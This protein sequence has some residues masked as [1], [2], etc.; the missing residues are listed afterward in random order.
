MQ[1]DT[2]IIIADIK[3]ASQSGSV[4]FIYRP[5]QE[6]YSITIANTINV[7]EISMGY[8][9]GEAHATGIRNRMSQSMIE[10]GQ[11]SRTFSQT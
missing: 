8:R 2:T 1:K 4:A 3:K 7:A 6:K 10:A 11:S 9:T 5:Q